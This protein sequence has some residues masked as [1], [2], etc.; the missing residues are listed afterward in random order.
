[1][2]LDFADCQM[3]W[4]GASVPFH[5]K[6][7]F[8]DKTKLHQ[9]LKHDSVGAEIAKSYSTSQAQR[10]AIYDVHDPVKVA[11]DQL[12]WTEKQRSDLAALF[13]KHGLLFSGRIGCYTKRQFHIDLKPGTVPSLHPRHFSQLWDRHQQQR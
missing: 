5:P 13:S 2:K 4:L 6:G 11:A 9:L 3:I 8:C 7:Y 1:M 10:H 12:H